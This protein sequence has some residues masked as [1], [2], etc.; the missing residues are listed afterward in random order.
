MIEAA[1]DH[2][3][4]VLPSL[5]RSTQHRVVLLKGIVTP[6]PR[7]TALIGRDVACDRVCESA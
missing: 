3:I 6:G 7:T 1:T 2:A 5:N 4:D